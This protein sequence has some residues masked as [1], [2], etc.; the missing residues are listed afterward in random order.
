MCLLALLRRGVCET[1]RVCVFSKTL[2]S[3]DEV[4]R[5]AAVRAFPLLLHHL[6]NSHHNLIG[7]ALLYA[8]GR[9]PF[10]ILLCFLFHFVHVVHFTVCSPRLE[11]SSEQVKKEL[12]RI[13]GQLSCIQSQLSQLS[14]THAE[15][16]RPPQILCHQLSLA[17]EH[18]GNTCPSLRATV[19]RPF[20]PLLKKQAPSSVK[21][22][23]LGFIV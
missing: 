13:I 6:G 18:A 1:W 23:T 11:D 14:E 10:M 9:Q 12:A 5:A 20:L 19:V 3:P 15:S 4:V 22:G 17:A 16:T 2:Q 7:S 21:Q 8:H